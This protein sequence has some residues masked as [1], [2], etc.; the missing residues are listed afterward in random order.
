M[1]KGIALDFDGIIVDTETQWF[2][3]YREWLAGEYGYDLRMEDYV[4]CVGASSSAL[5]EFLGGVLDLRET[6]QEFEARAKEEFMRRSA[7]LPALP[8]VAELVRAA[9]GE[10]VKLA[11][12][13]SATRAKPEFHLRRLG[14][15]DCFDALS[16]ADLFE[17]IKPA[18]DAY[19]K[20]AELLRIEPGE[21][22]AIEDSGNGLISAQR[23][24]MPCL[25]VKSEITSKDTFNQPYFELGSLAEFDYAQARS[26]FEELDA[27][28]R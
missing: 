28:G 19:L 8:G 21:C 7:E 12:A 26:W 2:E 24:G 14:L 27:C 11:I 9:K 15:L 10:G 22:L 13:T 5:F 16:T 18:P 23:A 4:G 20:A 25:V 3:I 17:H 1:L 6:A